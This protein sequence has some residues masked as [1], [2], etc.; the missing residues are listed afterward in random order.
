MLCCVDLKGAVVCGVVFVGC[1][2]FKHVSDICN[3]FSNG[4][5]NLKFA[6]IRS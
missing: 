5:K 1:F 3:V 6:L 2:T 4:E